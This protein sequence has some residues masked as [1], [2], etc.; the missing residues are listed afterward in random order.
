MVA[1]LENKIQHNWFFYQ[2]LGDV[3]QRFMPYLELYLTYSSSYKESVSA[4]KSSNNFSTIL[5]KLKK[6][7]KEG[8]SVALDLPALL[9][10]PLHYLTKSEEFLK[11]K[12]SLF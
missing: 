2:T 1:L 3:F 5:T 8:L 4:L 9:E 12:T 10:L 11:V 7:N 6:K